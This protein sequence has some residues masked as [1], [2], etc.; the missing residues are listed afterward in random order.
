MSLDSRSPQRRV[1]SAAMLAV[2]IGIAITATQCRQVED[3]LLGVR[4]T[5]PG[6]AGSC[7]SA[8][9]HAYN[10]SLSLESD[11]HVAA[12]QACGGA[13]NCEDAENTR[14]VSEVQRLQ[15]GRK[16]CQDQCHHQGGG[17]GGR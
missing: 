12:V 14:H 5:T 16:K 11:R 4:L 9:A 1:A 2:L 13:G 17:K 7:I 3:N 10:D 6:G 8:C 15:Q